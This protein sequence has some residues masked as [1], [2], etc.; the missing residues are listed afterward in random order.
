MPMK[1]SAAGAVIFRKEKDKIFYLFLCRQSGHLDFPKGNIEKGE[2][3]NETIRREVKEET[4]IK[5][6]K[7]I[8]GFKKWIKYFYKLRN[9]NI[10]KIVVFFLAE[11]KTEEVKISSEHIGFE[12]LSYKKA[13]SQLIFENAKG[14]LRKAN[15]FLK[16]YA[17]RS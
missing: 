14:V 7:F 5:D 8:P 10:F 6:I 11:T 2:K 17:S 1:K 16:K 15:Q 12:W 3:L 9:K 13:M 4:G